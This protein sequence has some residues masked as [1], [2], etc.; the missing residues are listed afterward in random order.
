LKTKGF[1]IIEAIKGRDSVNYGL[2]LLNQYKLFVTERSVNMISQQKRYKHKVDKKTGKVLNE[3]V[4][5]FDD[6]WDAAR[7]WAMMSVK[8]RKKVNHQW[9]GA[10]A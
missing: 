7:Y 4:K 5:M 3:P 2:S 10:T 6:T 1:R 8:P 9:R